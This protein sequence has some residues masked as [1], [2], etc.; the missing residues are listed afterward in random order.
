MTCHVSLDGDWLHRGHGHLLSKDA[1]H[2]ILR[3]GVRTD[4]A[5][6]CSS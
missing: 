5:L 4:H 2:R 3:H 6:L 1:E